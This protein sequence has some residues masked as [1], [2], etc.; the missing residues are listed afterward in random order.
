M[1]KKNFRAQIADHE[2]VTYPSLPEASGRRSFLRLAGGGLLAAV[3]GR[4]L[5]AC[6][7]TSDLAGVPDMRGAPADAAVEQPADGWF[8]HDTAGVADIG[9]DVMPPPDQTTTVECYG[10]GDAAA[11]QPADGWFVHDSAGM[12]DMGQDLTSPSD[13]SVADSSATDSSATADAGERPDLTVI[14][15]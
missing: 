5:S 15:P 6:D 3:L 14:K 7:H 8:L 12:P 4:T 10:P 11:E 1:S 2:T 13:S 9:H